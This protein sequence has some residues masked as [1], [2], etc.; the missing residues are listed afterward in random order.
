MRRDSGLKRQGGSAAVVGLPWGLGAG[1]MFL[2]HP[3]ELFEG[4][5]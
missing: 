2:N 1:K 3:R 4:R 5:I